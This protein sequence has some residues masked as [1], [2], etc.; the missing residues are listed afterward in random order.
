MPAAAVAAT[1]SERRA[2]A[3]ELLRP[4]VAVARLHERF[5][6]GAQVQVLHGPAGIGKTAAA[7]AFMDASDPGIP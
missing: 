2:T 4:D 6:D 3:A 5:L 1:D 7:T